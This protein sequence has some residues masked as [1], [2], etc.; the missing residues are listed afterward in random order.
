[1]TLEHAFYIIGIVFMS[2]M[3]IL[4]I[5]LMSA[6]VVIK[7][8]INHIHRIIEQKLDLVGNLKDVARTVLNK[9]HR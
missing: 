5:A 7:A 2:L 3:I 1:M 9:K 8:R 6:V 4:F